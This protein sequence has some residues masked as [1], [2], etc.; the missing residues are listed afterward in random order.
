MI[1]LLRLLKGY[2]E[3]CAEGGFPERFI[4]LCNIRGINLWNVKN[5]G[6]K[7]VAFTTEQE[8]KELKIPAENSGMTLKIIK[9]HGLKTFAKR[10]K[11]RCGA[12]LG[13]V[14]AFCFWIFMSG[15][16]WEIEILETKSVNVEAF[17][18]SLADLGVKIGARK[19][20]IDIIQVQNQL[21][22]EYNELLWV[23]LNIFGG[24]VQVEMSEFIEQK[25]IIDT[26]TPVNLVASKKGE[27]VLVKGYKGVNAVKE[28]DNVTKGAL[29]ISGVVKNFDGSEYFTHAKGEVFAKT[30]NNEKIICPY[31]NKALTTAQKECRYYLY[32]FSLRI[33]LGLKTKGEFLTESRNFLESGET[34]LPFGIIREDDFMMNENNIEYSP[35]Q[36]RLSGFLDGVKVKREKYNKSEL[37]SVE[38]E[39]VD[40]ENCG[41]INV[42]INCIEDIAKERKILTEQ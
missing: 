40:K 3:F 22:N 24:K 19:S 26:K 32:A 16:I 7:V 21:M 25:E 4:N 13:I 8:F 27:I 35:Q 31:K 11:W 17:T 33:P 6:V 1:Q 14:L 38:Y 9:S 28:G 10:H 34:V 36:A 20:K 29:L 37:K 41:E 5:D 12:V 30:K 2:V 42:K 18:E 23:S 15:F 39:F